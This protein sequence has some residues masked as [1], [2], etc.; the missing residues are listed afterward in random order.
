MASLNAQMATHAVNFLQ[1]SGVVVPYQTRFAVVM[2]CIAVQMDTPVMFQREPAVKEVNLYQCYRR[3]Q[4]QRESAKV[5]LFV[6]MAS[7]SAQ[8]GILAVNFLQGSGVVVHFQAQ[9]AVVMES[10]A[11]QTDTRVMF[12]LELVVKEVNSYQCYK[13]CQH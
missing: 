3:C 5:M 9:F 2:E 13:R 10:I 6:L 12:Q 7:L 8:M 1:D 4:H 11:A